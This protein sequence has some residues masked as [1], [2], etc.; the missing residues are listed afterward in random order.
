MTETQFILSMDYN[1]IVKAIIKTFVISI[2]TYSLIR[3]KLNSHALS[4][5]HSGSFLS[6]FIY[7]RLSESWF[8][9]VGNLLNFEGVDEGGGHHEDRGHQPTNHAVQHVLAPLRSRR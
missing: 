6:P 1:L 2:N 9:V 5:I 8:E 3:S 7:L 4:R